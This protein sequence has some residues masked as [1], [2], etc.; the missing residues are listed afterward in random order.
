[1]L[2]IMENSFLHS[3]ISQKTA[4]FPSYEY[5]GPFCDLARRI[6]VDQYRTIKTCLG[7]DWFQEHASPMIRATRGLVFLKEL[8]LADFFAW[9]R[10]LKQ[11][12]ENR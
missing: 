8:N 12:T 9:S 4:S 3:F 7:R 1:M 5:D 6:Q 10:A 2:A 11:A